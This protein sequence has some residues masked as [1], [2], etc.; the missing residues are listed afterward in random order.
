MIRWDADGTYHRDEIILLKVLLLVA[1]G[2]AA[3]QR[4]RAVLRQRILTVA[5]DPFNDL[6][7]FKLMFLF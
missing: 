2:V 7:E 4:Q 5:L 1:N 3:L 6:R